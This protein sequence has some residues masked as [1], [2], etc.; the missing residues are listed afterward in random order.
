MQKKEPANKK[1]KRYKRLKNKSFIPLWRISEY[2]KPLKQHLNAVFEHLR[3]VFYLP[4]SCFWL[5]FVSVFNYFFI[6][7]SPFSTSK[8]TLTGELRGRF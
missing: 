5:T 2:S 8:L 6:K 4:F 3:G 7:K 1:Q